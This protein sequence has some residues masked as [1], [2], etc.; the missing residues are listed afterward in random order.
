MISDR[1]SNRV[2]TGMPAKWSV[3]TSVR[4]G[5]LARILALATVQRSD[6]LGCVQRGRPPEPRSDIPIE[7]DQAPECSLVVFLLGS[8][9]ED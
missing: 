6:I 1:A 3:G 7:V 8:G 5:R 2:K 9:L 4:S